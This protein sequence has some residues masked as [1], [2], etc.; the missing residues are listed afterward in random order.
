MRVNVLIALL[1]A[2]LIGGTLYLASQRRAGP[3]GSSPSDEKAHESSTASSL[4]DFAESLES[5]RVAA[6]VPPSRDVGAGHVGVREVQ[7]VGILRVRVLDETRAPFPQAEV[8]VVDVDEDESVAPTRAA[9]DDDSRRSRSPARRTD[10]QGEAVFQ[11]LDRGPWRVWAGKRGWFFVFSEVFVLE[12]DK[13]EVLVEL[14]TRPV[15]DQQRIA[16]RVLAPDGTPTYATLTFV[17]KDEGILRQRSAHSDRQSGGFAI[18]LDEPRLEGGILATTHRDKLGSVFLEPVQ[19]GEHG[20]VVKL[21][22]PRFFEL[23]VRDR[24]DRPIQG[25]G[26]RF[27]RR[28]LGSWLHDFP[29]PSAGRGE[30]LRWGVPDVPFRIDVSAYGFEDTEHVVEDPSRIGSVLIVHLDALARVEGVVRAGGQAVEGASVTLEYLDTRQR[31]E[32]VEFEDVRFRIWWQGGAKTDAQGRFSFPIKSSGEFRLRAKHPVYGEGMLGPLTIDSERGANS[33]ELELDRALVTI[34]GRVL[35]PAGYSAQE[36]WLG[37]EGPGDGFL[38]APNAEGWFRAREL[39]A[40]TWMIRVLPALDVFGEHNPEDK[41]YVTHGP[42]E[43]PEW[44]GDDARLVLELAPGVVE[45]VELDLAAP[46]PCRLAG[47]VVVDGAPLPLRKEPTIRRW[48]LER[49]HAFL[50]IAT[51]GSYREIG[52]AI[53]DDDG[54]FRLAAREPGVYRMRLQLWT[55]NWE[56]W[57]I[58]DRVALEGGERIWSLEVETGAMRIR[59]EDEGLRRALR[60]R[61][62]YRW[63]GPREIRVFLN[64]VAFEEDGVFLFSHLPAGRGELFAEGTNERRVLATPTIEAGKTIEFALGAAASPR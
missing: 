29:G 44:L 18:H 24:D 52:R 2:L 4:D 5:S 56:R 19:G 50:E 34:E 58:F 31:L 36:L 22:E 20:L 14:V 53:L 40:G 30:P 60:G 7:S 32:D 9:V 1:L 27:H 45:S 55:Q 59:T 12:Q 39:S 35:P 38:L 26:A 23:D 11:E 63:L 8:F 17:W 28:I 51:D 54:R 41:F 3:S 21:R 48:D 13:G 49:R 43:P 10:E 62:S 47:S 64:L 25:F 33:L 61:W 57:E 46:A 42:D 15:P 6:L 37:F 16:G